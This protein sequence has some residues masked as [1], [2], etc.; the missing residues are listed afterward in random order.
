MA[1]EKLTSVQCRQVNYT[2]IEKLWDAI[3]EKAAEY[4]GQSD[5]MDRNRL[6]KAIGTFKTD[7]SSYKSGK[8]TRVSKT[9]MKEIEK[10]NYDNFYNKDIDTKSW[11][12]RVKGVLLGKGCLSVNG[13]EAKEILSIYSENADGIQ[14]K[15]VLKK[16]ESFCKAIVNNYWS[17]VKAESIYDGL[18]IWLSLVM[19]QGDLKYV[20][21]NN[22]NRGVEA[23][24][25]ISIED[26]DGC[27][28]DCLV[29]NIERATKALEKMKIVYEY[30]KLTGKR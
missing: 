23:F 12:V 13:V 8:K 24:N 27:D 26:L 16:V 3:A 22:V 21:E 15:E 1:E 2:I 4:E 19:K 7:F 28:L 17:K 25:A 6:Y 10:I 14:K 5:R 11:E 9:M 20:K 30:K 18:C 29:K